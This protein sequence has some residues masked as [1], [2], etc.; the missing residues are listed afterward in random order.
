MTPKGENTKPWRSKDVFRREYIE[1][2]KSFEELA[3]E[4]G[5]STTTCSNWLH[6]HGFDSRWHGGRSKKNHASYFTLAPRDHAYEVWGVETASRLIR[7]HQLVAIADGS[8][9]FEVFDPDTDIHHKNG[10][11][12]D[13][14]PGNLGLLTKSEHAKT[15]YNQG[16][17]HSIDEYNARLGEEN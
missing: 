8:D 13:N 14:R 12:W 3:E 17:T 9:P 16:D 15:H 11:P 10:I 1:N 5:C 4:W 2:E 6:R 7:V